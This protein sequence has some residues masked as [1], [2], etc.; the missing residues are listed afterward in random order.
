MAITTSGKDLTSKVTITGKVDTSKK[1]TYKLTYSIVDSNNVTISVSRK[2]IV[3]DSDINL[4][5][6]TDKYTN[7]DVTINAYV[8]D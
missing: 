6:N 8:I 2:V 4:S 7:N 1:G 3:M 5:L